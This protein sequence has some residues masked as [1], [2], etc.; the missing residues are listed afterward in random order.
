MT[1]VGGFQAP[2]VVRR[3]NQAP[4][5]R[6]WV[7]KRLAGLDNVLD[8]VTFQSSVP[9]ETP[10]QRT[11]RAGGL[12]GGRISDRDEDQPSPSPSSRPAAPPMG[13]KGGVAEAV[14]GAEMLDATPA[15]A[16][17]EPASTPGTSRASVIHGLAGRD[18]AGGDEREPSAVSLSRTD[19]VDVPGEETGP[20]VKIDDTVRAMTA[21]EVT[22]RNSMQFDHEQL[23]SHIR[24]RDSID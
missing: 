13:F 9:L 15:R 5:P 22:L 6:D 4:G 11:G 18:E 8:L 10:K 12:S 20:G 19:A 17:D 3:I 2:G 23:W 7:N 24:T 14:E 16:A 21:P 1:A